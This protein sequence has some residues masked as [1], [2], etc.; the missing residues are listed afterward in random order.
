MANE[1]ALDTADRIEVVQSWEQ[2]TLIAAEAIEAGYLVRFNGT[3]GKFTTANGSDMTEGKFY[4]IATR[5]CAAGEACTAIRRG[6]LDGYDLAALN[7]GATIYASDTDGRISGT[8]GTKAVTVG[9][10][11]P[12]TAHL[13]SASAPDKLLYLDP[14]YAAAIT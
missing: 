11:A 4:G 7:Y 10:I 13:L 14:T 2:L 12:G 1:I 9:Y 8:A 5:S 3:V 6:I